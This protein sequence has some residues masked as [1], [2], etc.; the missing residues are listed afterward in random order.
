VYNVTAVL[1]LRT[2]YRQD[3]NVNVDTRN[4]HLLNWSQLPKRGQLRR[5]VTEVEIVSSRVEM[6]KGRLARLL[7]CT[8]VIATPARVTDKAA[9]HVSEPH[10]EPPVLTPVAKLHLVCSELLV[11]G[12]DELRALRSNS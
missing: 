8:K 2:T 10:I 1:V 7:A 3:L 12:L 5:D 4:K 11:E 6:R 9:I